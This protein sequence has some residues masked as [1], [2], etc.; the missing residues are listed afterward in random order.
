[1][2]TTVWR[3]F[4]DLNGN[5]LGF[6]QQNINGHRVIAHGGDTDF[7]HTDLEPLHRRQRR[8]LHLGERARQGRPWAS[9]CAHSLF[10]AFADRYF[11]AA[12]PP[13]ALDR[14]RRHGQGARGDDRR[15]L[16]HH[17]ALGLDLP[18]AGPADQPNVVAA[19]KDGTITA[20]PLGQ[21][22]TF[23]EV[24]PFLWQQFNGHDRI[25]ATVSGGKVT[26]W[27]TDSSAPDLGLRAAGRPGGRGPG[28]A[29][30]DRRDGLPGADL[31]R[32]AGRGHRALAL[33]ASRSPTRAPGRGSIAWPASRAL[34]ALAAVIL[35]TVVL[36]LVSETTGAAV[37][38]M[39]H[40]GADDLVPGLRRRDG[41]RARRTSGMV[42]ARRR[43]GRRGIF[44]VLLLAAFGFMLWIAA[45][46]PP[47]RPQRGV[48]RRRAGVTRPSL[49]RQGLDREGV[50][51]AGEL[52][53]D[54]G[55][56][57]ALA[58]HA[59]PRPRRRRPRSPH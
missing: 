43:T 45:A 57:H 18:V 23:V 31:R 24:T 15:P 29:A 52:F 39:L 4:P 53:G 20:A 27:G 14:R 7:F 26:R 22:E 42:F 55:V 41:D 32:L 48:L 11:P 3:A 6:Y 37:G 50:H 1:M 17:A 34:L 49:R 33:W 5:L 38:A 59:R 2:H 46:L 25:Q 16:H 35:W 40:A 28:A 21:P 44:A 8:P 36:Q 9:S 19:N 10:E 56:D 13:P 30:G 51:R 12:A 58:L 54:G 47:D